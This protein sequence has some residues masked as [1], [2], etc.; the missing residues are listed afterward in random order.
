MF[1]ET[2]SVRS[3]RRLKLAALSRDA[4]THFELLP[5]GWLPLRDPL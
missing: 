5:C 3:S 1:L 4:A 2:D